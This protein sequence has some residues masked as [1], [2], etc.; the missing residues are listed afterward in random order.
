MKSFKKTVLGAAIALGLSGAASASMINVGGVMWDPDAATD[1]SSQ[2]INMRQFI[3]ATTGELTGFGIITAWNGT[4][5]NVFCPGCEVTFQFGGYAPIGGTPIPGVGDTFSYAGGWVK[6]FVGAAE[7]TNPSDY[8]TLNW[9]NTG[10]GTLFLDTVANSS[11]GVTLLGTVNDDGLGG[12]SGLSGIGRLDVVGGL[13]ASNF[14]TNT[15]P[16]GSDLRFSTSLTYIHQEGDPTDASGTGN[17][18]GNSIPE[19]GTLALL[20]LGLLGAGLARRKSQA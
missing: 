17:L 14:N 5:Q 16:N 20:G 9:A 4:A 2:S 15:Q 6:F 3:N 11:S 12:I 19:P 10:N 8:L 13:A 18:R 1:Y 7:I